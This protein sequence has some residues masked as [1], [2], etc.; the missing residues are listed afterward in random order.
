MNFPIAGMGAITNIACAHD[1]LGAHTW[2][3]GVSDSCD[4]TSISEAPIN[5]VT[6]SVIVVGLKM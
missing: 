5:W 3:T 2:S 6:W 1:W 4:C